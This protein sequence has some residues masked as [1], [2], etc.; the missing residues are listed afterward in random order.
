MF[1]FDSVRTTSNMGS[2]SIGISTVAN[3]KGAIVGETA[4]GYEFGRIIDALHIE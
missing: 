3:S 2:L 1:G 4:T